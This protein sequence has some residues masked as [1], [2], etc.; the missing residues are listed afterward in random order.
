MEY[1]STTKGTQFLYFLH[2]NTVG[3]SKQ[4]SIQEWVNQLASVNVPSPVV[5]LQAP[6]PHPSETGSGAAGDDVMEVMDTS[7]NEA[8][9]AAAAGGHDDLILGAEGMW[10]SVSLVVCIL[11]QQALTAMQLHCHLKKSFTH[12]QSCLPLYSLHEVSTKIPSSSSCNIFLLRAIATF[13]ESVLLVQR[14]TN[15]ENLA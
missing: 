10:Y 1:P 12:Y 4:S 3:L 7:Q 13:T 6:N 2:L 15:N 14:I 8:A 5:P 11:E 9:G